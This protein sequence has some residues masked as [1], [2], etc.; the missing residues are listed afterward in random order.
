MAPRLLL[1]LLAMAFG[2]APHRCDHYYRPANKSDRFGIQNSFR[3]ALIT[4]LDTTSM[5]T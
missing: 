3:H 5:E 1:A 2:V 4:R